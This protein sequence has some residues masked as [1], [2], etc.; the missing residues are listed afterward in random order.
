M[1]WIYLV[2]INEGAKEAYLSK[3]EANKRIVNW[4]KELGEP[5]TDKEMYKKYYVHIHEV[6]LIE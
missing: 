3:E 5:T 1:K 4:R 6:P 2:C